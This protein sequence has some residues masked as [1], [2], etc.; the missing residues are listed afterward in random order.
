[1]PKDILPILSKDEAKQKA[2]EA[3]AA[4]TLKAAE[5]AKKVQASPKTPSKPAQS[6]ASPPKKVPMKVQEIPPFNALKRKPPALPV[7]ET[8]SQNIPL[9]TSPSPSDASNSTAAAKANLNPN[10]SSFVFKP[11]P[12]A[13]AF[14]PVRWALRK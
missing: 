9:A 1:M 3:K 5:N 6:K 11:N 13:A 7:P 8:A 12:R 2:M 4:E 14:K 10:A